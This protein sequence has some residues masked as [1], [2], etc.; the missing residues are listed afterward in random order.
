M[1][2][3]PQ[4]AFSA[5]EL[6]AIRVANRFAMAPMTRARAPSRVPNE[7]M[8]KYYADRAGAGLI[9]TEATQISVQGT[10]SIAT[11]GIHT[12]EQISGWRR[13]TDAVSDLLFTP[14]PDGDENLHRY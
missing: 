10:G 1:S 6:G 9:I 13:V 8:A 11:P 3:V 12:A 14:S 2:D 7:I 5:C 4:I